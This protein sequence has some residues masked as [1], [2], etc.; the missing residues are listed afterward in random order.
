MMTEKYEDGFKIDDF[1]GTKQAFMLL[2]EKLLSP[3]KPN[4]FVKVKMSLKY[5]KVIEDGL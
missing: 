5:R 2:L 4:D 3:L 1:R